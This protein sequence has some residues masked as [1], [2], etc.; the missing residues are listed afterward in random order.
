MC[1]TVRQKTNN[2]SQH[3]DLTQN[4][5]CIS[6]SRPPDLRWLCYEKHYKGDYQ[7]SQIAAGTSFFRLAI[8]SSAGKQWNI[9]RHS[10]W[11]RAKYLLKT[12]G[13]CVI[14][15]LDVWLVKRTNFKAIKQ[16]GHTLTFQQFN[17]HGLRC[18]ATHFTE[19]TIE[20]VYKRIV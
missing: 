20:K 2:Q 1:N 16:D 18:D 5:M 12:A 8:T 4:T 11:V 10:E 6:S 7:N 15:R 9:S 3:K 14:N 13:Q 19:Y 17:N